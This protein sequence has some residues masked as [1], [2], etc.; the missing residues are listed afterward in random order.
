MA[1]SSGFRFDREGSERGAQVG[2]IMVWCSDSE[3]I[4]AFCCLGRTPQ[5]IGNRKEKLLARGISHLAKRP[6]TWK[7]E[8]GKKKGGGEMKNSKGSSGLP[9]GKKRDRRI[10]PL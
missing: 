3:I 6:T 9:V 5:K 8:N 10:Q 1:V 4:A 7:F 2:I